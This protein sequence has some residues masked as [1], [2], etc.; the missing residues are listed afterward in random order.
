M[1]EFGFF[2]PE[3][4]FGIGKLDFKEIV[5]PLIVIETG[6]KNQVERKYT[7]R[8]RHV[9]NFESSVANFT[10]TK[11]LK[12][13]DVFC[14]E[15]NNS[16]NSTINKKK[17]QIDGDCILHGQTCSNC[18]AESDSFTTLLQC[19]HSFCNECFYTYIEIESAD[20][21]PSITCM[22]YGCSTEIDAVTALSFMT[23]NAKSLEQFTWK[24]RDFIQKDKRLIKKCPTDGW[25][26]KAL[27]ETIDS[28]EDSSQGGKREDIE[29]S[30]DSNL[31]KEANESIGEITSVIMSLDPKIPTK[32][33]HI[34]ED[35]QVQCGYCRKKWCF[36]CQLPPHWPLTCEIAALYKESSNAPDGDQTGFSPY[37]TAYD[38]KHLK[39]VLRRCPHCS[40]IIEKSGGCE[41]V[42]CTQCR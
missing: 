30:T 2:C 18:S 22:E 15:G 19:G 41:N 7:F 3:N 27:K 5:E 20:R 40:V 1:K 8:S 10:E 21:K 39:S 17:L 32:D 25:Q 23:A 28:A 33:A 14:T 11:L 31:N 42:W 37:F 35:L 36:E 13:P 38:L 4:A 12:F 24:E 34:K 26:G 6:E 16:L 29:D 9:F